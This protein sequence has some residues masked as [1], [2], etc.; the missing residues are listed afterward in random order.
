LKFDNE[1][2]LIDFIS[3]DRFETADGKVYRNYPWR[4]PVREY[5]WFNGLH[6]PSKADLIWDRQDGDFCYGMF[7]LEEIRYN[8]T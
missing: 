8:I 7:N 4:T 6:L 5:G 1:G 2:K 3:Y